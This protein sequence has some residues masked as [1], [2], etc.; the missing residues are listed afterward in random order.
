MTRE[1]IKINQQNYLAINKGFEKFTSFVLDNHIYKIMSVTGKQ[2]KA[3]DLIFAIKQQNFE[4]IELKVRNEQNEEISL[5]LTKNISESVYEI[6]LYVW[7][8]KHGKKE[9]IW[10]GNEKIKSE[11]VDN[12]MFIKENIYFYFHKIEGTKDK[13]TTVL[14]ICKENY[15]KV[16][17][18]SINHKKGRAKFTILSSRDYLYK[19]IGAY[20]LDCLHISPSF[21]YDKEELLNMSE[22]KLKAIS[23]YSNYNTSLKFSNKEQPSLKNI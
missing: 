20:L 2:K 5:E 23:E 1:F 9:S 16:A 15:P 21:I 11:N 19:C 7:Y 14:N 22:E 4:G 3:I 10:F 17:G 18:I 6:L 13:F 12:R 8:L